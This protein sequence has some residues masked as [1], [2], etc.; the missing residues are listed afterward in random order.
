M[1]LQTLRRMRA[2]PSR[3]PSPNT[4][5]YNV[6]LKALTREG[7]WKEARELLT[8]VSADSTRAAGGEKVLDY[9][10]YNSV[11]RACGAAGEVA[12]VCFGSGFGGGGR[13]QGGS[14]EG[15]EVGIAQLRVW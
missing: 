13:H 4:V 5:C 1:A 8:E 12:E 15:V 9:L 2:S 6:A 3:Y 14:R 10:S 11:I 7:L